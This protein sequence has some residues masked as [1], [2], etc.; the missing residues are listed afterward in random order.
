MTLSDFG[1][2]H[3]P[4]LERTTAYLGFTTLDA[5]SP[6]VS[7]NEAVKNAAPVLVSAGPVRLFSCPSELR[8][9]GAR[10]SITD[11]KIAAPSDGHA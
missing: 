8:L 10:F 11:Q 4:S 7:G 6:L 3:E 1:I 9:R 5:Q 2:L